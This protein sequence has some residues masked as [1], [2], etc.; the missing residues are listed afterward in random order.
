LAY[1]QIAIH[2]TKV[3]NG[4][5]SEFRKL[6]DCY[7]CCYCFRRSNNGKDT[8]NHMMIAPSSYP[9]HRHPLYKIPVFVIYININNDNKNKN[10]NIP[11]KS[12]GNK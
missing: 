9:F 6:I 7:Y 1:C 2:V 4:K 11:N 12:D 8:P 10:K 3:T 5:I